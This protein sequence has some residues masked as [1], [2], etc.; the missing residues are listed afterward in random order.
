M[1]TR[2][3]IVA[4]QFYPEGR[5]ECVNEIEQ[6]LEDRPITCKLPDEITGGIVPHA[7]WVFSGA[8]SA[9]VFSAI[10]KANNQID[11]FVFLGAAHS[12]TG[13]GLSVFDRGRWVMPMG[14]VEIDEELA[15]SVIM[16]TGF[17]KSNPFAHHGEHSIEVQIPFVQYLFPRARILPIIVPPVSAAVDF[18]KLLAELVRE[19]KDKKVCVIASTD[20]THYGPRYGFYPQ[21]FGVEGISWAKEVNDQDFIDNALSLRAE[22]LLVS[23]LEKENSCGPGASAALISFAKAMGVENGTLLAHTHSYD[24]MMQKFQQKS[25][26]SVGYAAIVF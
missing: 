21:G 1:D 17:A 10:K 23:S 7:G 19:T 15:D 16:R 20:L 9:M 24:I 26:D 8:L 22:E 14:D 13:S 3:P 11:T 12:A 18:G 6:Y 4:G 25:E 5:V 2:K